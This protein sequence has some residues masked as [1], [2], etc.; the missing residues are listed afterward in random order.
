M[1]RSL[2]KPTVIQ[3]EEIS[4]N[5]SSQATIVQSLK[6][7]NAQLMSEVERLKAKKEKPVSYRSI[8]KAPGFSLKK[9]VRRGGGKLPTE[10]IVERESNS[11]VSA[12]DKKIGRLA[13]IVKRKSVRKFESFDAVESDGEVVHQSNDSSDGLE[14]MYIPPEDNNGPAVNEQVLRPFSA[15]EDEM[16]PLSQSAVKRLWKP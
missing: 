12:A 16:A 7:Q 11:I 2:R 6:M 5:S 3:T 9:V 8:A 10:D 13:R 4:S 15:S 14:K 1:L